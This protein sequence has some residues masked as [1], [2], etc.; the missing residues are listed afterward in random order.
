MPPTQLTWWRRIVECHNDELLS[1]VY[2]NIAD[3]TRSLITLLTTF[4]NYIYVAD[5]FDNIILYITLEYYA[6]NQEITITDDI[7][8]KFL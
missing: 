1:I 3:Y 8:N 6:V 5:W 7:N 4:I 2:N